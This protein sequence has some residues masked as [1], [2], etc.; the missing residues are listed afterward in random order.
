MG[1][2]TQNNSERPCRDKWG[3]EAEDDLLQSQ[4]AK[5]GS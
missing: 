1:F 4:A 2:K 5:S 3:R